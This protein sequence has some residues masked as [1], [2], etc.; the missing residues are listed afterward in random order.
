MGA[1][2]AELSCQS[3]FSFLRGASEPEA[4]VERAAELGYRGLA[5]TDRDG[6]YG[7]PRFHQALRQQALQCQA[8]E[9]LPLHGVHGWLSGNA[10]EKVR[11]LIEERTPP[12]SP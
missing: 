9:G 10:F 8:A 7:C 5:L 11:P 2:Y 6:L 12:A 4:L 1:E 3:G